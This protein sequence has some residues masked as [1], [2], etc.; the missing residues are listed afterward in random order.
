MLA[1]DMDAFAAP[2]PP[3]PTSPLVARAEETFERLSVYEGKGFLHHCKRLFTFATMLLDKEG[4]DDLDTEVAYAIAMVHD[5]GLLSEHEEGHNYMQRSR[6]LFWRVFADLPL[7]EVD[8]R[9][10]DECLLFNHRVFPVPNVTRAAECF[11]R[12]VWVEH[13]RGLRTYGLP[14]EAVRKVFDT[15]ERDDFDAVLWDFTKRTLRREPL[16][17]V[18]GIFF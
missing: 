7:P 2:Q 1:F 14:R 17:I 6:A 9:I 16:T 10:V 8:P 18:N 5:L 3:A 13:T 11:R 4:V 12:A 15:Y